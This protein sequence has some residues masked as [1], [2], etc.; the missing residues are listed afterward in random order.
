[1]HSADRH[2]VVRGYDCGSGESRKQPR[3][4]KITALHTEISIHGA[5]LG[6]NARRRIEERLFAAAGGLQVRRTSDIPKPDVPQS[7]QVIDGFLDA[8]IAAAAPPASLSNGLG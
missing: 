7:A 6:S 5:N 8:A 2:Q 1:M 3:A 4:G